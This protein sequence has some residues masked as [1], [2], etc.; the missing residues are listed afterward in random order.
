MIEISLKD[1]A[2]KHKISFFHAMKLA[3][4]G[5]IPSET[6]ILNDKPEIIVLSEEAPQAQ[7]VTTHEEIDYKKAYL[8]LKKKYDALLRKEKGLL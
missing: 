4:S 1:Y 7:E 3:K 8:D 6:R 5:A 2:I